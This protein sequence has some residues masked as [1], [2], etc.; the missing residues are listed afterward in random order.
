MCVTE[1]WSY[2]ECGC[3]YNHTIPCRSHRREQTPCSAPNTQYAPE[4]WLTETSVA[5]EV[6]HPLFRPRATS[7]EPGD[8]PNHRVVEKSFINQICEDCLLAELEGLPSSLGT[9]TVAQD[10]PSGNLDNG[11]GLIWDSEVKIEIE[12]PNSGFSTSPSAPETSVQNQE[13]PDE[14]G[15]ILESH[16]EIT[17]EDDHH[18]IVAESAAS[19]EIVAHQP[20]G[21]SQSALM[22]T[23]PSNNSRGGLCQ[24]N[25]RASGSKRHGC[26]FQKI[27][28]VN[29]DDTDSDGGVDL[30]WHHRD[31]QPLLRGRPL[32]CSNLHNSQ[33]REPD[34]DSAPVPGRERTGIKGFPTLQSLRSLSM[35]LRVGPRSLA[36]A[37]DNCGSSGTGLAPSSSSAGTSSKNP[38]RSIRN[39]KS[40]PRIGETSGS[41]FVG[42][43]QPSDEVHKNIP[44]PEA[45]NTPAIPPR[46]SSLKS[47]ALFLTDDFTRTKA[48][49]QPRSGSQFMSLTPSPTISWFRQHAESSEETNS[50]NQGSV[51]HSETDFETPSWTSDSY[52]NRA[53]GMK[54]ENNFLIPSIP[55][56]STMNTMRALIDG[57][58]DRDAG[59]DDQDETI[60]QPPLPGQEQ[61]RHQGQ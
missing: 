13:I 19:S 15:R 2:R 58:I 59:L 48:K 37:S 7:V 53:G 56:S 27:D 52:T 45:Q 29:L 6:S 54:A 8:C 35:S 49:V 42:L 24:P 60:R 55:K 3:F 61:A 40:S 43:E 28:V 14:D 57:S 34:A 39:R 41:K 26:A 23:S 36:V 38:F 18:S 5:L 22:Q 4:K 33:V 47:F 10:G 30:Q 46:K 51:S 16:V 9:S 21:Q 17:I 20:S 31:P 12:N 11:E 32:M 44:I 25:S 50:G 1:I